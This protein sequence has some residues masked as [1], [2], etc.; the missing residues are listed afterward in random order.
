[1]VDPIGLSIIILYTFGLLVGVLVFISLLILGRFKSLK[2]MKAVL[3]CSF[4]WPFAL[5]DL[6]IDTC[7]SLPEEEEEEETTIGFHN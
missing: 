6:L 2:E 7:R 5:L 4:F 3:L 1:M